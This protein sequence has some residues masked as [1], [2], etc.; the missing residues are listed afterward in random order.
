MYDYMYV[1]NN[2]IKC[3]SCCA[4]SALDMW[5]YCSGK[6]G[7]RAQHIH[8]ILYFLYTAEQCK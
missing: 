1:K 2:S 4:V 7:P 5:N 3:L 8:T 6:Q